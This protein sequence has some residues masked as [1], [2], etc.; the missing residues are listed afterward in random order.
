M[1]ATCSVLEFDIHSSYSELASLLCFTCSLLCDGRVAPHPDH[2]PPLQPPYCVPCR[3]AHVPRDE[4]S[5]VIDH[6]FQ[7]IFQLE[8]IDFL[9][10]GCVHEYTGCVHPFSC[11]LVSCTDLDVIYISVLC[12]PPCN[13]MISIGA[14]RCQHRCCG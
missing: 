8:C 13:L 2:L 4:R 11:A 12:L 3:G 14:H 10:F 6:R 9:Y 5:P 7:V 1:D